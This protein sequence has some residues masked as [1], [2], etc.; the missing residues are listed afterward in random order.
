MRNTEAYN[1]TNNNVVKCL[2]FLVNV[3]TIKNVLFVCG[4]GLLIDVTCISVPFVDIPQSY[5]DRGA[6]DNEQGQKRACR[7]SRSLLGS[8]SGESDPT[9]GFSEGKPCI[10]VKL[11]RIVNFRP[12]VGVPHTYNCITLVIT[13]V[14]TLIK[15]QKNNNKIQ[16]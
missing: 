5:K 6:L 14:F 8:C 4:I 12:R 10:I 3:N 11:N 9:Y 13:G 2:M 16:S 15:A 7:F 1:T